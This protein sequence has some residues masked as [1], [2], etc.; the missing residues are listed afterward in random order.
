MWAVIRLSDTLSKAAL[1]PMEGPHPLTHIRVDLLNDELSVRLP[2]GGSLR[3]A[4]PLSEMSDA[5]W[6]VE[7]IA[8]RTAARR[9]HQIDSGRSRW[10]SSKLPVIAAIS[11]VVGLLRKHG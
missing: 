9:R 10:G 11:A 2:S 5:R 8:D 6:F 7:E 4:V 1:L 3:W